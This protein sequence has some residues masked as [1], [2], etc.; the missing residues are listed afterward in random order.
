MFSLNSLWN[1]SQEEVFS[2][3]FIHMWSS[4]TPLITQ[5]QFGQVFAPHQYIYFQSQREILY[6]LPAS[7]NGLNCLC[8]FNSC[9]P[10]VQRDSWGFV[11]LPSD[12]C[13]SELHLLGSDWEEQRVSEPSLWNTTAHP[14][15]RRCMRPVTKKQSRLL[16]ESISP[17]HDHHGAAEHKHTLTRTLT[18]WIC[19]LRG[20][21]RGGGESYPS[22]GL[23]KRPE[24][25]SCKVPLSSL[26]KTQTKTRYERER[27]PRQ[28]L[29]GNK[30][31]IRAA[32]VW[33]KKERS[34]DKEI[35]G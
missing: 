25:L 19:S 29:E 13:F 34:T 20:P 22:E 14:R 24:T 3:F 16:G 12:G 32:S 4:T 2:L 8:V 27:R 31:K 26:S 33:D 15:W 6:F 18:A 11:E 35:K 23:E 5:G 21:W 10:S 7:G 9:S 30:P 17:K 28:T 1:K